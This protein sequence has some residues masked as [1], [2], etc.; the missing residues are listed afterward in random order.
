M[1]PLTALGLYFF[2]DWR[3]KRPLAGVAAAVLFLLS[4]IGWVEW[5]HFG[6]YAS[7]VG[8]VFFV[9]CLI[10]LDAFF[11]AWVAGDRGPTF[12]VAGVSF[13]V[14]TSALGVVSP[15]L[16]AAPLIAAF[17]YALALPRASA[18]LAWRWLLLVAPLLCAGVIL[19]S[20]FWLGAE[21]QYLA[22]V[23]SH[24]AG[25]GTNFDPAKLTAIDLGTLLSLSPLRDGNLGDLYSFTPAVLLPA[26]LGVTLVVKDGRTRVLV[27]L[28]V[29]G[30][31]FMSFRDLYRPLFAVPGFSEFAVVAHRPLLLLASVGVPSLAA[32]GLFELPRVIGG[33]AARRWKLPGGLRLGLGAAL[34]IVMIVVL[35]A[36]LVVFAGRVDPSG[37]LAYGPSV[38][39]AT[40][41]SDLGRVPPLAVTCAARL[42]GQPPGAGQARKH[43]PITAAAS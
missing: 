38:Y 9:P 21:L 40:M 43:L 16:L 22:V 41:L 20:A 24:W 33:L 39:G 23:R 25:A 10:A 42:P 1:M 28:T 15:H 17:V 30:I 27:G 2:F 11:F 8:M 31:V 35:A 7:W 36:D 6:L 29:L 14:L 34:P 26:I 19:L 4:P 5:T 18:R 13:V 37:H 3:L 32:L 12:R